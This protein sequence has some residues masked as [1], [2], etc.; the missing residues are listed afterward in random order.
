MY[1]RSLKNGARQGER[2]DGC[3]YVDHHGAAVLGGAGAER[4]HVQQ[5]H[6][7]GRSELDAGGVESNDQHGDERGCGV[8]GD[9]WQHFHA[10]YSH[11]RHGLNN[12]QQPE[13]HA[14]N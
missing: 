6:I 3:G 4:E 11:I 1:S 9:E 10:R 8:G 2:I 7:A 12:F 14:A 13:L 5:L